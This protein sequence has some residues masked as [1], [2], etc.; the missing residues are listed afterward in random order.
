MRLRPALVQRLQLGSVACFCAASF[1]VALRGIVR[2][3]PPS[4]RADELVVRVHEARDRDRSPCGRAPTAF[5]RVARRVGGAPRVERRPRLGSPRALGRRRLGAVKG[6]ERRRGSDGVAMAVRHCR[7]PAAAGSGLRLLTR[8]VPGTRDHNRRPDPPEHNRRPDPG[9]ASVRA[10]R[11]QRIG[12]RRAPGG[13]Q[14]R[15]DAGGEERHADE[16]Q[17]Q[18]DRSASSRRGTPTAPSSP[19]TTARCRRPARRRRGAAPG[20][21]T[22]VEDL[23]PRS[24]RAPCARRT[25]RAGA[26]PKSRSRR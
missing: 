6:E 13:A 4:R 25:P 7:R 17:R 20:R 11:L 9:S 26:S 22:C 24:R 15:Q 14:A 16:R 23:R 8:R 3:T 12:R 10:Q 21:S 5:G 18:R 2:D 19:R 1:P